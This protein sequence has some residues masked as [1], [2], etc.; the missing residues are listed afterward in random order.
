ME[1]NF[2]YEGLL[3][4]IK[5]LNKGLR[6]DCKALE[7]FEK[8]GFCYICLGANFPN[9]EEYPEGGWRCGSW[10]DGL[11]S[12]LG[13]CERF[14]ADRKKIERIKK[15]LHDDPR[16]S[17]EIALD[18]KELPSGDVVLQDVTN[19]IRKGERI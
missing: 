14:K 10:C 2:D 4:A 17:V 12:S 5:E 15:R 13:I 1:S 19:E 9:Q 3:V 6:G 18:Y 7:M 8:V 11:L 16:F